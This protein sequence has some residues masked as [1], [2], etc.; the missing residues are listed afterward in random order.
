M[1]EIPSTGDRILRGA[2]V[3]LAAL[4]AFAVLP[5]AR[6]G[7][8]LFLEYREPKLAAAL[9]LGSVFLALFVSTR[10]VRRT[11]R[12]VAESLAVDSDLAVLALLLCVMALSRL[13]VRVPENLWYELRQYSLFFTLALLLRW[14]AR[15]EP[16]TSTLLLG[17]HCGAT[18]LLVLIGALQAA[19]ALPWLVAIDPGYGVG[20]PSLLG[21]KNPMALAVV[22][23]IFLLPLLALPG[24]PAPP[25]LP[26][27]PALPTDS[28]PRTG[29]SAR[30]RNLR[31][32]GLA[33]L[34][35]LEC[36]YVAFLKSRTSYLALGVGL[37]LCLVLVGPSRP[38]ALA[39]TRSPGG[40]STADRGPRPRRSDL[41][42]GGL[43][44]VGA[45]LAL[46]LVFG[47]SQGLR[48]RLLSVKTDYVDSWWTSDR[49]T[50]LMNSVAMA[51]H[52]P[53]GVGLGD[54][55]THYPV[56]RA[57]NPGV[58]FSELVQ[59]RRA[60]DDHAQ[61]LGELGVPGFLT[62]ALFWC[63]L[64]WLRFRPGRK[65][66]AL[67][68]RLVGVQ[69]LV[70]LVAMAGDFYLEHPYLK[71]QFFLILGLPPS[72]AEDLRRPVERAKGPGARA[73]SWTARGSRVRRAGG[74]LLAL[75]LVATASWE[76]WA[77]MARTHASSLLRFHYL[78]IAEA[79]AA[80][81]PI[82]ALRPE[83][84]EAR[85]AGDRFI[86]GHGHA[87]TFYKDYLILAEIWLLSGHPSLAH[88]LAWDSLRLHPYNSQA[89]RLLAEIWAPLDPDRSRMFQE[90]HHD[91]LD[92]PTGGFRPDYPSEVPLPR[93]SPDDRTRPTSTTASPGTPID[94]QGSGPVPGQGT[95]G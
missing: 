39:P 87:K 2:L 27:L 60:H 76:A 21:Y 13:W 69:C 11:V 81:L 31:L 28:A 79:S 5:G 62:W 32:G 34:F 12:A 40:P 52:R 93:E 38:G 85:A 23:Q 37:T 58:A 6:H 64:L 92:G 82:D 18:A 65:G 29:A 91:I 66:D 16:R 88:E 9:L 72:G 25:A 33:C 59:P 45:L 3:A 95:G 75:A 36:V 22:G 78:R 42:K 80:G 67:R 48:S 35:I 26:G 41:A 61:L 46:G 7:H 8:L 56:Y 51:R 63:C 14:W 86:R 74:A 47:L 17:A 89:F 10:G 84:R 50:Y 90:L 94:R 30:R 19:G 71:L 68:D 73:A 44:L 1:A 57:H 4:P 83:L 54:W 15:R 43:V 53:F 24:P 49:G 55:Q 70:L 20:Y 77:L